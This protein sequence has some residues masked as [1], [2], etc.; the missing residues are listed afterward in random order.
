MKTELTT[1]L[2]AYKDELNAELI[3]IMDY[4]SRYTVD[5]KNGGFYGKI[6]RH[7]QVDLQAPKGSVLNARIL[8]SFSAAYNQDQTAYYL[9]L[10]QRAYQYLSITN[11]AG[12]TGR[13]IIKA[14]SW[15]LKNRFMPAHSL[16][17]R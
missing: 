5:D 12:F 11:L 2:Q 8:W 7:N 13:L 14:K 15:I 16:F 6:D 1:V 9:D 10:A 4:W 3:R 17:M